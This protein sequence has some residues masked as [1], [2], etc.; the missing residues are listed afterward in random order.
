MTGIPVQ[1]GRFLWAAALGLAL[2]ALF[3]FLRPLRNRL[4][5]L[6]CLL[7]GLFSLVCLAGFG[8][9]GL[10]ICRGGLRLL[11]GLAGALGAFL[12]F[13]LLSPSY[14]RFFGCSGSSFSGSSVYFAPQ[15]DF[16]QK[17][18]IFLKNFSFQF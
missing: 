13:H 11:H 18:Y 17:N 14:S 12:Y 2:G 9:L 16:S 10:Y 5:R 8:A 6:G 4:P 7:D 3:D 15:F 1:A